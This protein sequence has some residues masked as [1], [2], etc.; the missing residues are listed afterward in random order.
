MNTLLTIAGTLYVLL[1]LALCAWLLLR[2]ITHSFVGLFAAGALLEL[3]PRFGFLVLREVPGGFPLHAGL[4]P[5]LSV[6]GILGILS[7]A[8]GFITLTM[9]LLSAPKTDL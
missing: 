8:A 2:G 6:F 5:I 9:F 3:I 1:V 7:F 4:I